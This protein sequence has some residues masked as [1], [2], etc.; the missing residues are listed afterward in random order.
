[1]SEAAEKFRRVLAPCL[2][3]EQQPASRPVTARPVAVIARLFPCFPRPRAMAEEASL[4][5]VAALSR[6]PV[7]SMPGEAMTARDAWSVR[8]ST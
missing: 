8:G 2:H 5:T 6:Y 1:M 7:K 4:G 3:R